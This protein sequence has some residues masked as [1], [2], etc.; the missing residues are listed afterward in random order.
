LIENVLVS[1]NLEN[2]YFMPWGGIK[3]ISF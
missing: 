1:F 2:A 3:Y